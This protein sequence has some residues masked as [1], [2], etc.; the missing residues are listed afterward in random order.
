MT[1][2]EVLSS[3]SELRKILKRKIYARVEEEA[4]AAD[5]RVGSGDCAR[6]TRASLLFCATVGVRVFFFFLRHTTCF[7]VLAYVA[8]H[9]LDRRLRRNARSGYPMGS[10]LGGMM[11][12]LQM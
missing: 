12:T 4:R 8:G 1:E 10:L 11:E 9:V 3:I 5:G 7:V 2:N 6:C